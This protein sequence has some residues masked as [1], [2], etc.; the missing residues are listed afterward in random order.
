MDNLYEHSFDDAKRT[1]L[2]EARARTEQALS[3][4]DLDDDVRALLEEWSGIGEDT[5]VLQVEVGDLNILYNTVV[6][7]ATGVEAELMRRNH[8]IGQFLAGMSHEFRTPLN[9]IIG[10]CEMAIEIALENGHTGIA[11]EVQHVAHAGQLMLALTNDVLDLAKVEAGH[12]E[13]TP[14][15]VRAADLVQGIVST[16]RTLAAN[17]GNTL[18]STIEDEVDWLLVDSMRVQ[19]CLTNLVGNACKFT[20]NGAI[21]IDVFR[22]DR[23]VDFVVSDTGIGMSPTQ[24]GRLFRAFTQATASTAREY[25]GTGLGLALSLQ[26]VEAMGGTI[27]VESSRGVG[28]TFTLR[29]PEAVLVRDAS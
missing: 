8:E 5:A 4:D 19:Q 27:E 25:G 18:E 16:M 23:F 2:Q 26:L 22:R 28:S 7:H 14:E 29:L 13:L 21:R 6:E 10:Y 15:R 24:Q 12:L 11:T 1:R 3:R 20:E 17:R 9:A